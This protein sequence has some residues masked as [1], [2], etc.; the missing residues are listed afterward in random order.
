[1]KTSLPLVALLLAPYAAADEAADR[2]AIESI[3]ASLNHR[4][5]PSADLFTTDA[6][7]AGEPARLL[8]LRRILLAPRRPWSEVSEPRVAAKSIRL[9]SPEVAMVEAQVSQYG[10]MSWSAPVILIMKKESRWRIAILRVY[11]S[12]T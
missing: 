5:E 12:R 2:A 3:V 11:L 6:K 10:I 1:M 9:I 7:A 4:D 8:D